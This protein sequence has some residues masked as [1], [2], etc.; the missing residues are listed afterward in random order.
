VSV[1]IAFITA[2]ALLTGCQSTWTVQARPADQ[3][4]LA[5]EPELAQGATAVTVTV[6]LATL[7]QPL[8]DARSLQLISAKA[9]TAGVRQSQDVAFVIPIA[10]LPSLESDGTMRFVL[11]GDLTHRRIVTFKVPA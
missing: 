5:L 7:P 11:V 2:L 6:P 4:P 8:R 10:S 9:A 1:I 3:A